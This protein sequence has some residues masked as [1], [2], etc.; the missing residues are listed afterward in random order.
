MK[1]NCQ[2][3]YKVVT[4]CFN[5]VRGKALTG[6]TSA[7]SVNFLGKSDVFVGC[8]QNEQALISGSGAGR[9]EANADFYDGGAS[10]FTGL[11][12]YKSCSTSNAKRDG[13]GGRMRKF[14]SKK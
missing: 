14:L 12:G 5:V 6:P 2:H 9:R 8:Q 13:K 10:G 3:G 7:F 11:L 1:A 4:L